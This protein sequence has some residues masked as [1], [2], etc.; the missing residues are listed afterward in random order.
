[1]PWSRESRQSRGY[2]AE[3]EKARQVAIV[4]DKE[5]CQP[6]LEAG[7]VRRYRDVDHVVPKAEAAKRGWSQAKIDA[8]ENLQCICGP[9]HDE[10]T[11]RENGRAY[12]APR[13]RIGL[14]GWPE[15][16]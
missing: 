6:C 16:G 9:C 3:W 1:M 11:A 15:E 2:G 13:P 8:P 5:L 10:K 7:R 12:R 4:R 14:D